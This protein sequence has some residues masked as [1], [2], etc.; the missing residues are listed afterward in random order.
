MSSAIIRRMRVLLVEDDVGMAAA[1]RRALRGAGVVA[2][3]ATTSAD[4]MWMVRA[5]EY[6]AVVLDVMLP[7]VDGIESCRR[8]RQ[9][10]IWVPV[11]MLTAR[12]AVEDRV[13][14]LD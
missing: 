9:D 2:D 14:G 6:D 4:A 8:L 7:D 10:G 11:I 5:A 12:D 1:A 13:R 3:V